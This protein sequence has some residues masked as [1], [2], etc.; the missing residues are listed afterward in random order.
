[1]AALLTYL[2]E[3]RLQVVAQVHSHPYDAFHSRADDM[4]AIIR[5]IGALSLVVPSFGLQT[6]A[7]TFVNDAAVYVLFADNQWHQVPAARVLRCY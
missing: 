7:E 4:W 5:H 3:S 1:M 6:T 2:R